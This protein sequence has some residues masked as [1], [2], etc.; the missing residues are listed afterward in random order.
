MPFKN[1]VTYYLLVL[2]AFTIHVCSTLLFSC[3]YNLCNMAAFSAGSISSLTVVQ[4]VKRK[5]V[6]SIFVMAY[7]QSDQRKRDFLSYLLV[8]F[9]IFP[10]F[11]VWGGVWVGGFGL[12]R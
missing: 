5:V 6:L 11:F 8:D 7:V 4:H 12:G 9:F 2:V 1:V 3:P 10:S